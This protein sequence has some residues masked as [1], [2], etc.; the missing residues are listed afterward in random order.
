[1]FKKKSNNNNNFKRN[2]EI[3][4]QIGLLEKQVEQLK[5][6]VMQLECKHNFVFDCCR[7]IGIWEQYHYVQHKCIYCDKTTTKQWDRAAKK[8]QQAL[9][10]LNLVPKDWKIKGD[11]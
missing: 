11:K 5:Q 9:K 2:V 10:L 3:R 1:M 4:L 8:E 6:K 7:N